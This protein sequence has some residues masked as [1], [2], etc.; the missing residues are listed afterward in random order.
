LHYESGLVVNE[1]GMPKAKEKE[2]GE[3]ESSTR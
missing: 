2:E 1:A 3:A